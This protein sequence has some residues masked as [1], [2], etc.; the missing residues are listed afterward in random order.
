[1]PV[2]GQ[3]LYDHH[4][5]PSL[6]VYCHGLS[7]TNYYNTTLPP[8]VMEKNPPCTL[9]YTQ[10]INLSL[11]FQQICRIPMIDCFKDFKVIFL[12]EVAE[13]LL[14][15]LLAFKSGIASPFKVLG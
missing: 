1:M 6:N 3:A 4:H 5:P 11:T 9:T 2:V 8:H 14:L 12:Q 10:M 7:S 13:L 15:L